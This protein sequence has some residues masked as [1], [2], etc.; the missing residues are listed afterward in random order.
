MISGYNLTKLGEYKSD[1]ATIR[2]YNTSSFNLSSENEAKVCS[3]S[4]FSEC[5][6]I[7]GDLV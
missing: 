6:K 1:S 5:Y 4:G 2:A 7:N 3:F